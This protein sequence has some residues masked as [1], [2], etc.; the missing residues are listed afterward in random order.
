MKITVV[1]GEEQKAPLVSEFGLSL[2]I[3]NEGK[4]FLFDTGAGEALIPNLKTLG[5]SC[6]N[7]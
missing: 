3:E 5:H 2:L 4:S 6:H 1:V 7:R